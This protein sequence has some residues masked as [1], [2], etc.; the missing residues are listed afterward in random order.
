[1][2]KYHETFIPILDVMSD[3]SVLPVKKIISQVINRYYTHLPEELL[4]ARVTTGRRRIVDR[5]GWGIA[6][7]KMAKIVVG[8]E[9]GKI[10]MTDKG[11]EILK[12]GSF[13]I[14]QLQSDEDYIAHK[15]KVSSNK[16]SK[17]KE[18]KDISSED[19][20]VELIKRGVQGIEEQIKADLL[21]KLKQVDS[22]D[23]GKIVLKLFK[24]MN[25]GAFQGVAKSK[26]G[27]IDG[28]INQ[29]DLGLEKVYVQSKRYR[30]NKVKEIEIR[31]FI[32]AMSGDTTKGIFVTA[33]S[34][35]K[36]AQEK[37]RSASHTIILIN[38]EQL[39]DL[40]HK[41]SIGIEVDSTYEVK[42]I[43]EDF[44]DSIS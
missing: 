35:N 15:R 42:K 28:I 3:K 43:D 20:P 4:R 24:A 23:F 6:Y 8:V 44:F 40:M 2:P 41:Y 17:R 25:Y 14:D 29:D 19:S 32:G 22:Y 38:G 21:D 16:G 33:S 12:T 36:N 37:A 18:T 10:Q 13:T 31:N 9:R 7:L 34:F 39:V 27:G 5:V 26:D 1:M 11:L 30:D